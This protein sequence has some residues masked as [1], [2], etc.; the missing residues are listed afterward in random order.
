MH[1]VLFNIFGLEIKT[2]G[3]LIALA[4]LTGIYGASAL[5]EKKGIKKDTM[6]D[7]G[8]LLIICGLIGSR[9]LYV[10]IWWKYY[11][12]APLD[13]LK[14]WEGGL[15]YYGGFILAAA[16]GLIW[17]KKNKLPFFKISDILV[18]FLALAH[19]IARIGCFC[20]GCCY[21]R[22]DAHGIIFKTI[23]DN[24]PHLPTQIYESAAN[25]LNFV[26]LILFYRYPGRKDGDVL[27][28]YLLNYGVIRTIIEMFR[29][30][31]ERGTI[32]SM[33]TSTFLSI[34]LI[35]AGVAG[36]VYNRMKHGK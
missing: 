1:P 18:P 3:V 8:L 4:F 31:P 11:V 30:D 15:V 9:L 16:G 35:V 25:F 2:Y 17:M 5:A 29:A 10:I 14:V 33:S 7:L 21:G 20:S 28:L 23:G 26:V 22:A 27:Y 24:I 32:F 6:L 19:A 12:K 34:F 36:L 13:I